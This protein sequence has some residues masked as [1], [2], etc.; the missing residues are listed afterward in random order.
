MDLTGKVAL[1]TGAG[2]NI[3]LATAHLLARAGAAVA[4]ND[5]VPAK[6]ERAAAAV[7]AAGGRVLA[8]PADV[9][10]RAAVTA[11]VERTVAA[12]G[13]LDILVNSHGQGSFAPVVEMDEAAWDLELNT[14]LK[15]TFLV[16]QAGA[17]AMIA[18]G[19][20]GRIVCLASTA[21]E[22]A[23]VG[24]AS[25]CASK[26]GVVMLVKVLALELGSHG[27]RVNAVAPGLVPRPDHGSTQEYIDAF[28]RMVPLGRLGQ[29]DDIA[30]AIGF[31]ASDEA[32]WITGEVLHVDGGFLAGRA[33]PANRAR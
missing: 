15:G 9:R 29:A 2:Q 28:C 7:E 20:G 27:I 30:H 18:Q 25:H 6:A 4:V 19:Q 26:A 22:S 3:G 32:A 1:V 11:M 17:R 23:R 24:G 5:V 31:L 14:N 33:L 13:R 10:D 12:L 16:C 21:A 8:V